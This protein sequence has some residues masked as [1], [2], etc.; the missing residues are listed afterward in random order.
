M[1][2]PAPAR[3]V[4][5]RAARPGPGPTV[6]GSGTGF[7]RALR[8]AT[9]ATGT[10]RILDETHTL[11]A[12]PGGYTA[13]HRLTP[14][15][16][17]LGKALAGGVPVGAFGVSEQMVRSARPKVRGEAGDESGIGG[18]LSG[19]PLAAAALRASPEHVITAGAHAQMIPLARR[20]AAG[21]RRTIDT[22][23]L[24]WHVTQLGTR[25]EYRFRAN[26]PR[27]GSEALA[28]ED[29]ELERYLHL[30]ALNGEF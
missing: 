9:R 28:A 17:T 1:R 30:Y 21:V 20:W 13:A 19:N 10:M 22:Y 24:P 18:T 16:V 8:N 12:G 2:A 5:S 27:N 14:D 3:T 7:H 15:M 6:A 4:G 23:G 25:A 11:C 26:A 29:G